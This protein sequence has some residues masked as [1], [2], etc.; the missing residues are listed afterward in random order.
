VAAVAVPAFRK[1]GGFVKGNRNFRLIMA[2]LAATVLLAATALA[3]TNKGAMFL[4]QT[5]SV[6]GKQLAGGNYKVQWE[7]S[8]DQV[9]LKVYKGKD[10]VASAPARVLKLDQAFGSDSSVVTKNDD[11]SMSLSEIRFSGKKFALQVSAEGGGAAGAAGA[12]K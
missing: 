7:G 11:G 10:V 1:T 9:E 4:G 2:L 8:G 12:A 3:E 5:T 6:A